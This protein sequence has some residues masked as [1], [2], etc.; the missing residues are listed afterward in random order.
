MNLTIIPG[1][2]LSKFYQRTIQLATEINLSNLPN[3][4]ATD[5]CYRFLE[6]LRNTGC[7]TIQGLT[8]P[9]WKSITS[10]RR[11]PNHLTAPLPWSFKE[12]YN[13]LETSDITI[14]PNNLSS[15]S[16]YDSPG[17]VSPIAA[18]VTSTSHPSSHNN[19]NPTPYN[20]NNNNP[21]NNRPK[22]GHFGIHQTR[23]GR[24]F[25]TT[26]NS[27]VPGSS[28]IACTLCYNKHVNPWHKTEDCPY[29]HPTHIIDKETRERVLQHNAIF[30][31]EKKHFTKTQ[32]LPHNGT[33]PP[34]RAAIGRS[35][36]VLNTTLDTDINESHSDQ[37]H[38][39]SD[40][41]LALLEE[42]TPL[43]PNDEII[44][45]KYFDYPVTPEANIGQP[46]SIDL[47]PDETITDHLQ[48][49]AYQS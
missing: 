6:L 40:I 42:G 18:L 33:Q 15:S 35:V 47:V 36:T 1:E 44:D 2:H 17:L 20:S 3:G 46:S 41:D 16:S 49:L 29:K 32:D 14:L 43:Q 10:H 28:R 5:L 26:S 38:Q 12:V 23:D 24:K 31:T 21:N 4:N 37:P 19:N 34:R 11:N 27:P 39:T 25:I 22:P 45:T 7:P 48:Y 8:L 30:G 13:T 9:Y